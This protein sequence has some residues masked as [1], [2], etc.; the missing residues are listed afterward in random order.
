MAP[1][2]S[3]YTALA[4]EQV[5]GVDY[6]RTW[7]EPPNA[8]WAVIA[9]HGGSIEGG[10]GTVAQEVAKASVTV[11]NANPFFETDVAD[12][13]A[14]SAT[15]ARSTVRAHEGAASALLTSTGTPTQAYAR[16]A[17]IP[18][19]PGQQYTGTVWC[20][21]PAGYG[22]VRGTI[23]WHDANRTYLSSSASPAVA[24]AAGTWAQRNVTGVAPAGAA[25]AAFGPTLGSNPPAGTQLWFDEAKLIDRSTVADIAY[26]EFAGIKSTNNTD[27]H[28]TST[29]FDEPNGVGLVGR[30]QR[31]L[32][33]HGYTGT[34]GVA[35]TAI[36]G[37]DAELV[38]IL[39]GRLRAA[40]F[41][42]VT[43]PSEIAGTDSLNICNRNLNGA[44]VQLEMSRALRNSFFDAGD[45]T[46]A[47]RAGSRADAFFRY[48]EA[49]RGAFT[50]PEPATPDPSV[51][52]AWT[53]DI[54][55]ISVTWTSP[56]GEVLQ[57]SDNSDDAG[58]F[59]TFGVAGWGATPFEFVAD[60]FSRGGEIVRFVR[61]QPARITWPL[62]VWGYTHQE[63]ID[64]YRKLRRAFLMTAH[65]GEPGWLTVA[66]PDG[67]ARKIAA[68][69]EDG[70]GGEAGEM[71]RFANPVLTLYCPEGAWIDV[72][73]TVFKRVFAPP[74]PFYSSFPT[75]SPGSVLGAADLD[76]DGD[77]TAWPTWKISGPMTSLTATNQTTSQAFTLTAALAAGQS[78]TITTDRPTVRD[79][80]NHNII[81]SINWP[82]AVL[83]GLEPGVNNVAF[84]VAGAGAGTQIELAFNPR[85]EGC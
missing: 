20:Y 67:S 26:Y 9:I 30:S 64:R 17:G 29:L 56:A 19:V 1:P 69:Y 5:E 44:G 66:R 10:S 32:S 23:D 78:I 72:D 27:L 60:G 46:A 8:T 11:G 2:Y 50:A 57:L 84:Q 79:Q 39:T 12:W 25:I 6:T 55:T 81:G 49:I 53:E 73:P 37:L 63:F 22:N 45:V 7:V 18:V 48:V 74:V 3:S 16:C 35:E 70:F 58:W 36:G 34:T 31:T 51:P 15:I 77:L 24:L 42:V 85:Y 80:A 76:N 75:V 62:H 68:F 33:F 61:A 83:W 47:A 4:A 71:H 59:T 43:T 52:V 41:T 28:I 14:S 65:R 38:G 13:S 54:G 82:S 21:S 40:G